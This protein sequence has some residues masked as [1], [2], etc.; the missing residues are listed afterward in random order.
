M[1]VT[2]KQWARF[3]VSFRRDNHNASSALAVP[4]VERA[5]FLPTSACDGSIWHVCASCILYSYGAPKPSPIWQ[6]DSST[7]AY[8]AGLKAAFVVSHEPLPKKMVDFLEC[9]EALE[10]KDV[11]H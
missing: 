5:I 3:I 4:I 10:G 9:L 2:I 11:K 7:A 1:C 8:E 6:P